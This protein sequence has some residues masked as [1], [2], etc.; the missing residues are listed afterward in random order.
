MPTLEFWFEM[1]STYTYLTVARIRKTAQANDVKVEWR[2]FLLAPI[3]V[4]AGMT[5]GPFLPY[6][7]KLEYMWRDIERRALEHGIPYR[8]PQKYPP[9]EVL[10]SA[11]IALLGSK[12]GWGSQ[13]VENAFSLHWTQGTQ[14]GTETNI[15]GALAAVGQDPE[16]TIQR[17]RSTE[18]KEA[19]KAQTA[20]A[21]AKGIFGSPTFMVGE[22][23]FWGDDR[24]E[25][26]MQWAKDH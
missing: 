15:R 21:A 5:E 8:R 3:M 10:T 22:E 26:A 20:L 17:A 14:I 1:G 24:L 16:A 19:L 25:Q 12:E 18:I 23:M 7:R 6:P 9:D 13:F 2:P 11:R 4:K